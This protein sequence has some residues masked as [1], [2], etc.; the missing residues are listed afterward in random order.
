MN[1]CNNH[2]DTEILT[3]FSAGSLQL[4]VSL[5]VSTHVDR[6]KKCQSELRWLNKVGS[7]FFEDQ[8][9]EPVSENLFDQLMKKVDSGSNPINNE[10]NSLKPEG[11]TS[12][13]SDIPKCLKQFI[14]SR[15]EDLNW[16]K[17]SRSIEAVELC[18]E[19]DGTK[20][21]LISIKP[22]ASVPTHSH[23]YDEY[24]TILSGS[25]SDESGVYTR[26]DFILRDES[27]KHTPTATLDM[28]CICLTVTKAPIQMT[29]TF[30]RLL[31]PI[32]NRTF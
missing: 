21:E 12:N 8:T 4:S 11:N 19:K 23:K 6:C 9:S 14:P 18:R 10:S 5:C 1:Y 13:G 25:F 32:L 24:T 7:D 17:V 31:N 15:L 27:H 29:G 3:A 2:P 26:G 22:G 20:V 28:P 16:K 30:S